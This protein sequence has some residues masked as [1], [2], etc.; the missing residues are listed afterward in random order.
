MDWRTGKVFLPLGLTIIFFIFISNVVGM[1]TTIVVNDV[2]WWKSPTSDPGLT[3]TL[4]GLIVVLSHY[5]GVRV[6]GFK[7]YGKDY[8]RPTPIIDRK[9]TRLNSSHVAISYA[10]C[11]LKKKTRIDK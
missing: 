1:V 7:E 5:Y 2:S 11:C 8:F 4:A 6:K 3:L 9:S 10:V